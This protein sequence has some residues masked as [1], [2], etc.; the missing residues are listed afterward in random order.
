VTAPAESP[1]PDA[2]RVA[3]TNESSEG[4]SA[5]DMGI[6]TGIGWDGIVRLGLVQMALGAIIV[7]PT[8]T[9]NRVMVV[10]LALAAIV[11][12][13]RHGSAAAWRPSRPDASPPRR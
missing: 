7:L 12:V 11:G 1:F 10:E 8:S 5:Q 6:G 3:T 4:A 2:A 13:S 9:L